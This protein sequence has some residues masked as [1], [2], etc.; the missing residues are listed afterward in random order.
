MKN[1]YSILLLVMMAFLI[2]SGVSLI[3]TKAGTNGFL[4]TESIR[5]MTTYDGQLANLSGDVDTSIQSSRNL[6]DFEPNN[7]EIG[8]FTKEFFEQKSRVDQI[9]DGLKMFYKLPDI[10]ILSI[11]IIPETDLSIYRNVVWFFIGL[12]IFIAI[13]DALGRRKLTPN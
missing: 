6:S 8:D 13:I 9:R 12:G 10:L 2:F 5:I 11:P 3:A 4:D 1:V 7:N